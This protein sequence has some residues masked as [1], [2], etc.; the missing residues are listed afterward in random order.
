MS[1]LLSLII[2]LQHL[3]IIEDMNLDHLLQAKEEKSFL[4]AMNTAVPDLLGFEEDWV[5][6]TALSMLNRGY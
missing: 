2:S 5:K 3:Y 1:S 6:Q 4:L